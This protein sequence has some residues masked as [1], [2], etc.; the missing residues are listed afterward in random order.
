MIILNVYY[1]A[2]PG[3]RDAFYKAVQES[4]VAVASRQEE[5]NIKYDYYMA[6]DDA[7]TI[8]LVEHW[9]DDA[10]FQFHIQ[11]PHFKELGGIKEE[12]VADTKIMRFEE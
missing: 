4:G 10:A 11:Q 6:A 2:K 5:G 3:K 7:D 12:Y 9:K 1:Q 8:L